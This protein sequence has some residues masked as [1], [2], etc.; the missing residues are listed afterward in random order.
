MKNTIIILSLSISV[1]VTGCFNSDEEP[2]YKY[3]DEII[4]L[5]LYD[6]Y[7]NIENISNLDLFY[8]ITFVTKLSNINSLL[9][10]NVI[11]EDNPHIKPNESI[12][13]NYSS[14]ENFENNSDSVFIGTWN[15]ELVNN[16]KEIINSKGNIYKIK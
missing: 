16:Q 9:D 12:S 3:K 14:I 13:I 8:S 10:S 2:N 7:L 15:L 4:S 6:D 11:M 1:F 5:N